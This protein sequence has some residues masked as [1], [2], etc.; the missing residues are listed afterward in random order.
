MTGF[1]EDCELKVDDPRLD[2]ATDEADPKVGF[3]RLR[4]SV[5]K[6]LKADRTKAIT[7]AT[8]KSTKEV[9]AL[10]KKYNLDKVSTSGASG[11]S[12]DVSKLTPGEKIELGLRRNS[13]K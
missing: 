9:A 12:L 6:A 8:D 4:K 13:E 10:R 7:E 5:A 11:G 1:V 3:E 2:W